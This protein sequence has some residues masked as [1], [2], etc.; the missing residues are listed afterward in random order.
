MQG[1]PKFFGQPQLTHFILELN[2]ENRDFRMKMW[3]EMQ[4]GGV[5]GSREHGN[6]GETAGANVLQRSSIVF[7]LPSHPHDQAHTDTFSHACAHITAGLHLPS[8]FIGIK[9]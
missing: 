9:V 1:G 4:V 7:P 6:K 5:A 3:Q 2:G 8:K